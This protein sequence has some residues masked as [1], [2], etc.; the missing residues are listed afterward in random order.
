MSKIFTVIIILSLII[1]IFFSFFYS[2]EI[3]TQ[4][5][6]LNQTQSE[7]NKTSLRLE[8]LQ[9]QASDLTSIQY[10]NSSTPS[11]FLKLINQSLTLNP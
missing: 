3:L 7:I 9:K 2:N 10:L 1:Q 11:A 6:Q 5:N 8:I 4:N